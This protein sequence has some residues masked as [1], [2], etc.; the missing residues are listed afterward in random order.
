MI[1]VM[2]IMKQIEHIETNTSEQMQERYTE[3][4]RI[5]KES[6]AR[7][8]IEKNHKAFM[9]NHK[10]FIENHEAKMMELRLL[11][12]KELS[13]TPKRQIYFGKVKTE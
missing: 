6:E 4:Y 3:T 7:Q 2:D 1:D 9:E 10:T 12:Q 5:I 13:R 8:I 11:M